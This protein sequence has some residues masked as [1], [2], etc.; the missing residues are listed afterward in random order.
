[1]RNLF[2]ELR[3]KEFRGSLANFGKVREATGELL[4]CEGVK[5]ISWEFEKFRKTS[6]KL[7]EL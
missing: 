4:T 1:M 3:E 7:E 2:G 5:V 6:G